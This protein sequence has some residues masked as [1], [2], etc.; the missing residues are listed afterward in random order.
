ME[1]FTGNEEARLQYLRDLD[2]TSLPSDGGPAFNRLIFSG[3]PYLLQHAENP[4]D[5]HP[6]GDAAFEKAR[7]LDKPIFLSIGYA[8]CHWCHVMAHESFENREIA[9]VINRLFVPIKVDREERP[10]IDEQYM[11]AAQLM[12]QKGGWPLNVILTPERQPFYAATYLPPRSR[13]GM[14][15]IIDVFEQIDKVWR[16][17]NEEIVQR[18]GTV[19]GYLQQMA[20]FEAGILPEEDFSAP[21]YRSLQAIYDPTWG[22]LGQEPKFPMP[23]NLIFLLHY[24]KRH[25]SAEALNMVTHTLAMMRRGGIFDQLGFGFHR[26]SVDR[27]WL[28]PHFEKMLYDQALLAI[29]YLQAFQFTGTSAFGEVAEA[30][31]DY[32]VQEMTAPAGAFYAALDADSEGREGT[33]YLW[34]KGELEQLLGV[35]DASRFSRLFGLG[36]ESSMEGRHVLWLPQALPDYAAQEGLTEPE[37][38]TTINS[39]RAS[40]LAVRQRRIRPLRDEKILTAWNGLMIAALAL[41]YGATG[42]PE[43]RDRAALAITS[44][45]DR[46]TTAGGNLRRV[47]YS[48]GGD[49]TGLLEDYAFF[50]WGLIEMYERT[51]GPDYL[52]AAL[53]LT[54][55]MVTRF[56]DDESRGFFESPVDEEI[57]LV[58]MKG[59]MDG[60]VPAG[61]SLAIMNLVRLGHI[62]GDAALYAAGEAALQACLGNIARQPQGY[63]ALMP[64]WDFIPAPLVEV[65][66]AGDTDDPDMAKMLAILGR[67]YIPGLIVRHAQDDERYPESGGRTTMHICAG[68]ACRLPL[69]SPP[70]LETLLDELGYARSATP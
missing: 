33:Y 55:E 8:T 62:T 20:T 69:T 30:I 23:L 68:G 50:C 10:D 67:R 4:V 17:K 57:V 65:T 29:A 35:A 24:A 2:K 31:F 18:A 60:V 22:G 54:K 34:D 41:G 9:A 52:F 5:W 15:G 7:A 14:P 26:Y 37:L 16:T 49:L 32:T 12:N 19:V 43:Y 59:G 39:W 56:R 51:L 6:W 64:V 70:E 38:Q 21:V 11:A 42:K 61:N 58:R 45:M 25:G 13:H 66:V 44:I 46:M 63:P 40:L 3:S 47:V 48:D 53:H 27:R 36:K 28:V 1:E